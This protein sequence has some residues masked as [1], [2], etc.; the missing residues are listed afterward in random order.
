MK[1]ILSTLLCFL[2]FACGVERGSTTR[3]ENTPGTFTPTNIGAG[4]DYTGVPQ[5]APPPAPNQNEDNGSPAEES[6]GESGESTEPSATP[7]GDLPQEGDWTVSTFS[8]T[9]DTCGVGGDMGLSVLSISHQES[10]TFTVTV[11]PG[12]GGTFSCSPSGTLFTCTPNS[13]DLPPEEGMDAAIS[14]LLTF[15]GELTS[16]SS[17]SANLG[18]AYDCT[19]TDCSA[20]GI[21]FPCAV[22]ASIEASAN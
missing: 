17:L 20:M 14:T 22:N 13:F 6:N 9:A 8:V 3:G 4:P 18:M 2:L 10:G 19:G 7:T 12:E 11:D 21:T 16:S 5:I 1:H 15:G